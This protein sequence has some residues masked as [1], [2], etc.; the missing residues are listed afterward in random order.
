MPRWLGQSLA[1]A[2][3]KAVLSGRLEVDVCGLHLLSLRVPHIFESLPFGA[4]YLVVDV[5]DQLLGSLSGNQAVSSRSLETDVP[6]PRPR[7]S[8]LLRSHRTVNLLILCTI[9]HHVPAKNWLGEAL[10]TLGRPQ[11]SQPCPAQTHFC[12]M[13]DFS[14]SFWGPLRR[15]GRSCREKPGVG[16]RVPAGE[17]N[18]ARLGAGA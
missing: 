11:R 3:V 4:H 14:S 7:L 10:A 6:A 17:A 16:P 8:H 1:S 13:K 18:G 5:S 12:R 15:L 2:S 9:H